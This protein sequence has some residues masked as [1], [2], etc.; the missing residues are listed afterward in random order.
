MLRF[1]KEGRGVAVLPD[2]MLCHEPDLY[3]LDTDTK[4]QP[5]TCRL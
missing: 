3:T 2:H 5:S 4:N 1:V